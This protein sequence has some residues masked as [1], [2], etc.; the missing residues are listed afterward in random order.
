MPPSPDRI[1]MVLQPMNDCTVLDLSAL[2]QAID[3]S[4]R[5]LNATTVTAAV[6][7]HMVEH[8]LEELCPAHVMPASPLRLVP[9]E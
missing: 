2:A 1:L 8:Q 3:A 7:T 4:M 5:E 9:K 6:L